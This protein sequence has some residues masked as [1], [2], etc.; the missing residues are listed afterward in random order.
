MYLR[1]LSCRATLDFQR[2]VEEFSVLGRD[3]PVQIQM[4]P[5]ARLVFLL[6]QQNCTWDY[7]VF[8]L[9]NFNFCSEARCIVEVTQEA[10]ERFYCAPTDPLDF[11]VF[12]IGRNRGFKKNSEPFEFRAT[13]IKFDQYVCSVSKK[14]VNGR[15]VF[16]MGKS[17]QCSHHVLIWGIQPRPSIPLLNLGV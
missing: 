11:F 13:R 6:R 16:R 4:D 12:E 5:D 15:Y 1:V 10:L 7:G 2:H 17:G 3:C 9:E 14:R 8:F